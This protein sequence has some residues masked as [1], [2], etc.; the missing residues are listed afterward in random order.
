[1]WG[2]IEQKNALMKEA[3]EQE[4]EVLFLPFLSESFVDAAALGLL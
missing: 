3:D 4:D 1:M 2:S